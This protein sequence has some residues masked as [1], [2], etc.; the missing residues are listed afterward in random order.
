[1]W[2][3]LAVTASNA[4]D[5]P[6]PEKSARQAA[7]LAAGR[8][9]CKQHLAEGRDPLATPLLKAEWPAV[10]AQPLPATAP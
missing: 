8:A 2:L 7:L 6:Q 3:R 1:M 9:A 10:A 4:S 5:L